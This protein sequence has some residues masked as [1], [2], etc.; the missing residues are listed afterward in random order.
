MGQVAER[1]EHYATDVNA[2]VQLGAPATRW[3]GAF[4]VFAA[5]AKMLSNHGPSREETLSLPPAFG[6][7]AMST[8][9]T[10]L[11][12]ECREYLGAMADEAIA[13]QSFTLA[14]RALLDVARQVSFSLLEEAPLVVEPSEDFVSVLG[15]GP[16]RKLVDELLPLVL[17]MASS[18]LQLLSEAYVSGK[19]EL[20]LV[21]P[22][23]IVLD[24]TQPLAAR[25][26][27]LDGL[28]AE[29]YT[30]A[31]VAAVMRGKRLEPWLALGLVE[32][33]LSGEKSR[34]RLLASMFPAVVPLSVVPLEERLDL[35]KLRCEQA[36]FDARVEEWRQATESSVWDIYF[37]YGPPDDDAEEG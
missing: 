30:L 22:M 21:D 31:I 19:L 9:A 18:Y 20:D 5:V 26:L 17:P 7:A 23:S 3:P 1:G 2:A 15:A 35:V 37:P 12:A 36:E 32:G 4:G 25:R 34:L 10:L 8:G 24:Q 6:D 29:V 28:R 16:A 11:G 27:L 33:L 13:G 14:R